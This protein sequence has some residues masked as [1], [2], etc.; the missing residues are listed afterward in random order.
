MENNDNYQLIVRRGPQPNQTFELNKDILSLGRDITNDIVINDPEVSRHHLR[1][2]RS[3]NG[4]NIEDLG[5]TNGTFINSQRLSGVRA[6]NRGDTIG[7]GET[8]T[9]TY[10]VVRRPGEGG[11]P[12]VVGG[13]SPAPSQPQP[14][15]QQYQP[16]Q[17]QYQ[18]YQPPATPAPQ[19]QQPIY[20]QQNTQ[21]YY[22]QQPPLEYASP[23]DYGYNQPPNY[24]YDPYAVREQAPRSTLS[25]V[26]IGC[27]VLAVFCCCSSI[28][29]LVVIDALQLWYDLPIIRSIAPLFERIAEA[30]GL[31]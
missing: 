25:W 15:P 6:L 31:V 13:A 21:D 7:L 12:T 20:P 22:A 30:L 1:L 8:V 3:A 17:S 19:Y 9:L 18:P 23:Q 11:A 4:Y 29:G 10:D 16:P 27:A 24:D 14:Q 26:G 5:S 2:T 28:V